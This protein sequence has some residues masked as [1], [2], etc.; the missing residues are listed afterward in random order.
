MRKLQLALVLLLVGLFMI[1]TVTAADQ[2]SNTL[3]TKLT[4]A[5]EVPGPGDPDGVGLAI[6]TLDRRND[7]VCFK[8]SVNKIRLPAAAAHIHAGKAGVAGPVVVPLTPPDA[9]GYS[10]GCVPTEE[11]LIR[12]IARSPQDYYVNVHNAPFPGGAVRGQLSR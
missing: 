6:I 9:S 4:G 7:A 2:V 10:E 5:A 3:V 1:G 11:K 8:I 12:A